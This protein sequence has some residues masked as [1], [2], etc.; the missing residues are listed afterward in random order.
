MLGKPDENGKYPLS[1]REYGA[2]LTLFGMSVLLDDNKLKDRLMT[3]PNGWEDMR[4]A[5]RLITLL[6]DELI[7]TIPEKKVRAIQTELKHAVCELKINPPS[8]YSTG[9]VYAKQE[10]IIHL[11]DRAI[12]MDCVFCEK[13]A[14]ECKSCQLYKDITDCF[15]YEMTKPGAESCP[16]AGVGHLEMADEMIANV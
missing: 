14:K 4:E 10:S 11:A 7:N 12:A 15:P 5:L 3:I 6:K 2:L 13:S 8:T 9:C 1:M 16:F